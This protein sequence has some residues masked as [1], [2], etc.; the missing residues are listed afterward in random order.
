[1]V[2]D[3]KPI[4][5]LAGRYEMNSD[6]VIRNAATKYIRKPY[7]NFGQ[8]Y[9]KSGNATYSVP[10][11]LQEIHGIEPDYKFASKVGV[12]I[13]KGGESYHFE[14]VTA[15]AKFLSPK[16]YYGVGTVKQYMARRVKSIGGW[17]VNY[18]V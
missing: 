9:L 13:S 4:A 11:L 1:M 12:T 15:A 14:T 8:Y 7:K 3:F 2:E 16:I 10:R 17:R 6:G 5:Q 18:D